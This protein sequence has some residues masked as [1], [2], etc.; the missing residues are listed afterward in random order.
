MATYN[1]AHFILEQLHS[2]LKQLS[3]NDEVIVSDDGSTD[4]TLK[5][6]DSVQDARVRVIAGAS[7]LGYIKN[8][9]RAVRAARGEYI[10][11]ADQDDVWLPNK[12]SQSVA[13]LER[14]ACVASDATV[15]NETLSVINESYF[16]LRRARGFS[17]LAILMRPPIVGA[18]MAC[19][20]D[21]LMAMLPFPPAV[22]HDFWL[23]FNAALV[24][25][26]T[27][28]PQP[29]ILF[30]RHG[31]VTSLSTRQRRRPLVTVARERLALLSAALR[32]RLQR[33]DP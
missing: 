14:A 10:F 30:R 2:I 20:R 9:E 3:A 21:F 6:V 26:L 32:V 12:V 11:F 25:K 27:V 1:G 31:A 33:R 15:V 8:F 13:A 5:L 23:S 16:A 29:T 7:R 22:P 18:T 24:S 28:L 17:A 19:R 4:A